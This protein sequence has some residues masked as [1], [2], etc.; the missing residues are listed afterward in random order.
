MNLPQYPVTP[1]ANFAAYFFTSSG[2]MGTFQNVVQFTLID[3]TKI[4]SLGFGVLQPD[5]SIDD[6]IVT[7]NGNMLKI[8]ATVANTVYTFTSKYPEYA[9]AAEGSTKSRTN[10]Y[11][12]MLI[13]Y[14]DTIVQDFYI[15]GING[16]K[17]L[18]FEKDK[19]YEAYSV[20]RK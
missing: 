9:V 14:Y 16:G 17:I 20:K 2:K 13:Q 4:C 7:N 6:K 19:E 10:L 11:R 5:G 15:F 12:R 18:P 1:S 8:L 3:N